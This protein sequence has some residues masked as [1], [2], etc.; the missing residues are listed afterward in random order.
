M[1]KTLVKKLLTNKRRV[2]ERH[3]GS[4]ASKEEDAIKSALANGRNEEHRIFNVRNYFLP[5]PDFAHSTGTDSL[6]FFYPD[7]SALFKE[8]SRRISKSTACSAMS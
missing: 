4:T 5:H 6:T 1:L 2:R 7:S 8:Q 3:V